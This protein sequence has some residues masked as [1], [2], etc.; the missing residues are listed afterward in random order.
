M[1]TISTVKATTE[2]KI[3]NETTHIE[4]AT[5]SKKKRARKYDYFFYKEPGVGRKK[6]AVITREVV[7]KNEEAENNCYIKFFTSEVEYEK[8]LKVVTEHTVYG[9]A[10][11][12][13]A[14]QNKI[15]VFYNDGTQEIYSDRDGDG[16]L[17]P[18]T[19]K[20]RRFSKKKGT[21]NYFFY[22]QPVFF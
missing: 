13:S 5:R 3:L 9:V 14:Q 6:I 20:R 17:F 21:N 4:Y 19:R 11:P 15:V 7:I 18:S 1:K 2:P 12:L 16:W 22:P 8:G 10:K